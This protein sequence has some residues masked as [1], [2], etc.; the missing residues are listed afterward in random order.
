VVGLAAFRENMGRDAFMAL[1]VDA[2]VAFR[3]RNNLTADEMNTAW[4]RTS[5]LLL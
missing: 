5:L 1:N 3:Y 4:D 2:L